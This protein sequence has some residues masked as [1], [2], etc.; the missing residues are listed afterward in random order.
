MRRCYET[1][2][3]YISIFEDDI[4]VADGWMIRTLQGLSKIHLIN[5]EEQAWLFVHLL[6]QDVENRSR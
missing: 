3:P 5:D 1:G 4:L 2:D 6:S